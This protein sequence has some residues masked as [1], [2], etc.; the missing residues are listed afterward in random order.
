MIQAYQGSYRGVVSVAAKRIIALAEESPIRPS[1]VPD[2]DQM[3]SPFT[4]EPHLSVFDMETV[5]PPVSTVVAE[6]DTRGYGE[7][8]LHWRPFPRQEPPLAQHARQA[9]GRPDFK[10][11]VSG[12]H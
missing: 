6:Q 1:E 11:W 7:R 3:K 10:A 12:I 5:A 4:S 8:S 9:V 2:I